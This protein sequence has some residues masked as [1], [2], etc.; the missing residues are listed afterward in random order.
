MLTADWPTLRPD[1]LQAAATLVALLDLTL[2]MVALRS[3][4][5]HA[6]TGMLE[7]RVVLPAVV[8]TSAGCAEAITDPPSARGTTD[9]RPTASRVTPLAVVEVAHTTIIRIVAMAA[10]VVVEA[11]VVASQVAVAVAVAIRPRALAP[12]PTAVEVELVAA[13][14]V[15]IDGAGVTRR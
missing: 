10:E 11:T 1:Q 15:N 8:V 7:F 6:T 2:T 9:L 13:T 5:K 12:T 3:P 14:A 4:S